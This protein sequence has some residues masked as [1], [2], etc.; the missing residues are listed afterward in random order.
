MSTW[1]KVLRD[2]EALRATT[3]TA[4]GSAR[5]VHLVGGGVGWGIK[6]SQPKA[7]REKETWARRWRAGGW[8]DEAKEY[9]FTA[10]GAGGG[11]RKGTGPADRV[12]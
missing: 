1:R 4:A 2:F 5:A 7:E 11:V 8:A 9:G 6:R 3:H 10:S 12:P